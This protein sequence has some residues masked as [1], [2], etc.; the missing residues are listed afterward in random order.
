MVTLK[1]RLTLLAGIGSF[2]TVPPVVGAIV[3]PPP[4][5]PPPPSP[6]VLSV[7]LAPSYAK[8]LLFA[9]VPTLL[10]SN[11]LTYSPSKHIVSNVFSL[12]HQPR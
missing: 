10:T 6:V 9:V 1:V 8:I 4:P 5:P 11:V 3:P 12:T 2:P 7:P